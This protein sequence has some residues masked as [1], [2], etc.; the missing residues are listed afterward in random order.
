MTCYC[1]TA[2]QHQT[3]FVKG[4]TKV[5][6]CVL[7]KDPK[8]NVTFDGYENI[9]YTRSLSI[10][11]RAFF[12]GCCYQVTAQSIIGFTFVTMS[13]IQTSRKWT[14]NNRSSGQLVG[15]S[16]SGSGFW[17]NFR[18]GLFNFQCLLTIVC[19]LLWYEVDLLAESYHSNKLQL[20]FTNEQIYFS[21][22]K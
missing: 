6:C 1:H 17:H 7:P 10:I 2:I 18:T 19:I 20:F 4:N 11:C 22:N 5:P 13:I 15:N 9:L 12:K 16:L 8:V 3:C 14:R 21:S